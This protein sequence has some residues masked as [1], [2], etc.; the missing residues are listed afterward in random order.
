[1]IRDNSTTLQ[2]AFTEIILH[3]IF[4]TNSHSHFF[5]WSKNFDIDLVSDIIKNC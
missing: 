3:V 1:M 2:V 4:E 5:L